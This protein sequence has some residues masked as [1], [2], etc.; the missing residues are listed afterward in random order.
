LRGVLTV[1][2]TG[3]DDKR[4]AF[5]NVGS[6]VDIAAPGFDVVSLRARSTDFM[7]NSR[8]TTYV[9]EDAF[10]GEDRRYY[11]ST[12]TSFATP[13]VTGVASLLLSNNPGLTP[14]NLKRVLEQSA[15]DV[16]TPGRDRF[17]GYGIVDAKA[18]LSANPEFYIY[19]AIPAV[20]T[21]TVND[22]VLVQVLGIADADQFASATLELGQGEDPGDWVS[23]GAPLVEP[24]QRGELGR[25]PAEQLAGAETWTIRVIV[26]HQN[27]SKRE[28]RYVI[29][30]A[31][32]AGNS[33]P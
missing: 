7:F 4:A 26:E 17:T 21:V 12:G 20:R 6:S 27:G 18:A 10:L 32:T 2:A 30:M 31:A 8:E 13:I 19:A 28:A 25:I 29:D 33:S 22:Q 3:P 24:V 15:R 16:E 23:A 5:S 14:A 11:R 9:K 1:A